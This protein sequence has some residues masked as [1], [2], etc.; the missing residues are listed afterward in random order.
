MDESYGGEIFDIKAAVERRTGSSVPR[1][2]VEGLRSGH[3][4]GRVAL[5]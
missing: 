1:H 4:G 3:E 2:V 5:R